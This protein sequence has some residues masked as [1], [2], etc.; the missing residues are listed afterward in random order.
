MLSLQLMPQLYSTDL[1]RL[2]AI[3]NLEL[4][5]TAAWM[6]QVQSFNIWLKASMEMSPTLCALLNFSAL[7]IKLMARVDMSQTTLIASSMDSH[8]TNQ[9]YTLRGKIMRGMCQRNMFI[10]SWKG[11]LSIL[12]SST[13]LALC[14]TFSL[15]AVWN[16]NLQSSLKNTVFLLVFL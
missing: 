5:P 1:S 13:S 6:I 15:S 16:L 14:K 10:F 2:R 4:M 8:S 11:E 7:S 12:L 3:M 9:M